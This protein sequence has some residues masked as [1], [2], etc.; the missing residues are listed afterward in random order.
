METE[1]QDTNAEQIFEDHRE[2]EAKRLDQDDE[3]KQ[4]VRSREVLRD[5][6]IKPG[7]DWGIEH[8]MVDETKNISRLRHTA[9]PV[10]KMIEPIGLHH[11]S[12]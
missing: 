5:I 7:N 8:V 2:T 6:W 4:E 11:Q 12:R 10:K 3:A 1:Q 9:K